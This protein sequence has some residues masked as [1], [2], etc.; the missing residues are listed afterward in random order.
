MDRWSVARASSPWRRRKASD[1]SNISVASTWIDEN[2]RTPGAGAI[3]H[4]QAARI[5]TMPAYA[6]NRSITDAD[7]TY[8]LFARSG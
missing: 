7:M 3:E 8:R 4:C 1:L 5:A 2:S 6:K